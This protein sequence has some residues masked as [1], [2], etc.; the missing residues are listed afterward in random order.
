MKQIFEKERVDDLLSISP[1][2]RILEDLDIP[3]FL[4]A[5]EA[6]E[7]IAAPLKPQ[8]LFQIVCQG[9]ISIYYVRDDGSKYSLAQG[10][11]AYCLGEMALFEED[12]TTVFAQAVTDVICLA[13]LIAGNE[14]K[15]L[16]SNQFLLLICK[17]MAGKLSAAMM[18]DAVSSS[19][20]E[21]VWNYMQFKCENG[22]L[23]GLEK[24]A[25]QLH[26]SERQLQRIMNEFQSKGMIKKIGKGTYQI[27]TREEP[28]KRE[29]RH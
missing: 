27:K 22:I 12:N 10:S 4:V 13:F 8:A 21:R 1:Y 11:E 19:I 2:R 24:T 23:K 6:G 16:A 29:C 7:F 3:L 28:K 26:C 9:E 5:Y 17:N 15:L 18:R 14:E 20:S 25:F